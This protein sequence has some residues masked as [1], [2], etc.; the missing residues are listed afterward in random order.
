M[1]R[2]MGIRQIGHYDSSRILNFPS[3]IQSLQKIRFWTIPER[4][5][6]IFPNIDFFAVLRTN[7]LTI[8]PKFPKMF[9]WVRRL[10]IEPPPLRNPEET[11]YNQISLR[12]SRK[13]RRRLK[14][15]SGN[16]SRTPT[17]AFCTNGIVRIQKENIFKKP[18]KT[19]QLEE[20]L[21]DIQLR[22]KI[23]P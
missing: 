8:C 17:I 19:R 10:V 15:N 1:G 2:F 13:L 16:L 23:A 9:L 12:K 4:Y 7:F 22:S 20:Y 21:S 6:E 18:C 11:F 3:K 14:N 5:L